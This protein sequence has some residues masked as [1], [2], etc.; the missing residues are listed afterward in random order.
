MQDIEA[1]RLKGVGGCILK[2]FSVPFRQ[3]IPDR[4]DLLSFK[5]LLFDPNSIVPFQVCSIQDPIITGK[6]KSEWIKIW[7]CQT[8]HQYG[9]QWSRKIRCDNWFELLT[10]ASESC[11]IKKLHFFAVTNSFHKLDDICIETLFHCISQRFFARWNGAKSTETQSSFLSIAT[12]L[13]QNSHN[14][15]VSSTQVFGKV[16]YKLNAYL[17]VVVLALS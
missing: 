13:S 8:V 7:G 15:Q 9:S 5:W 4:L 11:R 3:S 1:F 12:G 6:N 17:D 2:P 14:I 16:G 10:G